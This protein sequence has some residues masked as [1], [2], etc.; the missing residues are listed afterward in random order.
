MVKVEGI[1]DRGNSLKNFI[2]QTTA[3]ALEACT[4]KPATMVDDIKFEHADGAALQGADE[5]GL[6]LSERPQSLAACG[7]YSL[8]FCW[9]TH[10]GS[11]IC[12]ARP[13]AER[14]LV[15]KRPITRRS[16][17]KTNPGDIKVNLPDTR[18]KTMF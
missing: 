13:Q 4:I 1:A 5:V 8:T 18:L 2:V 11:H 15:D 17:E 12:N 14:V 9:R 3:E 6:F 16:M 10:V 7:A